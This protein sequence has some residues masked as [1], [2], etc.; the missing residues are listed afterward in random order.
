MLLYVE[1]TSL[2]RTY[3]FIYYVERMLSYAEHTIVHVDR[4]LLYV[5]RM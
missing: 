4:M 2:C 3:V 5:E 1:S